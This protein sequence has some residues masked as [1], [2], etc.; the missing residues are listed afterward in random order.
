M[1]GLEAASW[2]LALPGW[3]NTGESGV[4]FMSRRNVNAFRDPE[5]GNAREGPWK[6]RLWERVAGFRM[7]NGV[8]SVSQSKL[9]M[10]QTNTR[11]SSHVQ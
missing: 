1:P 2:S 5:L 10:P 4:A 3:V 6:S 9:E 8:P 7:A 11:G